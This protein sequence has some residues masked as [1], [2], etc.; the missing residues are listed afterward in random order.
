M[1]IE[2][3]RILLHSFTADN[4]S[5][6]EFRLVLYFIHFYQLYFTLKVL[7]DAEMLRTPDQIPK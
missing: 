3:V 4:E 2:V 1:F 7:S 5:L 6:D